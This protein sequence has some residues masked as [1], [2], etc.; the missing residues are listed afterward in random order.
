MQSSWPVEGRTCSKDQFILNSVLIEEMTISMGKSMEGNKMSK[1]AILHLSDLHFRNSENYKPEQIQ[2][3]INAIRNTVVDA[4]YLLLIVSGDLVHDG[5]DIQYADFDR[6]LADLKNSI[7]KTYKNI[8]KV[9]FVCVPGNHDVD[10]TGGVYSKAELVDIAENNSFDEKIFEE[11]ARGESYFTFARRNNVIKDE[12][13]IIESVN[14]SFDN[15][16][17]KINL[18]NTAPFSARQSDDQGFHFIPTSLIDNMKTSEEDDYIFTVMHHPYYWF[19]WHCKHKLINSLLSSTDI[20]FLGHDHFQES[21]SI[22]QDGLST[23]VQAA[24][25]LSNLGNW[26]SSE[27]YV[28]LLDL[29]TREYSQVLCHWDEKSKIYQTD[30]NTSYFLSKNRRN[31]IGLSV[32]C[33]FLEYSVIDKSFAFGKDIRSYYVF[34]YLE[35]ENNK[36]QTIPTGVNY[37]EQFED[38]LKSRRRVLLRGGKESGKS[39]ASVM[40]HLELYRHYS[41]VLLNSDDFNKNNI[42]PNNPKSTRIDTIIENAIKREY[43]CLDKT[44]EQYF[45][46]PSEKKAIII[47]DFDYIDAKVQEALI[48]YILPRYDIVLLTCQDSII[49]DIHERARMDQLLD[50]FSEFSIWSFTGKKRSE[51]IER[52]AAV[53]D[54]KG[55]VIKQSV[56]IVNGL[57]NNMKL[58][59][60]WDPSFIIQLTL[61]VCENNG[62]PTKAEG[63]L[64]SDVVQSTITNMITPALK[65]CKFGIKSNY[66]HAILE[67]IAY[68]AHAKEEYPITY[69]TIEESINEYN[70]HHKY[71]CPIA[72]FIETIVRANIIRCVGSGYEFTRNSFYAFFVAKEMKRK[73]IDDDDYSIF[74]RT[75]ETAY[76][77]IN[78]YIILFFTYIMDSRK[79]AGQILDYAGYYTDSWEE[80]SISNPKQEYFRVLDIPKIEISGNEE[81]ERE[82]KQREEERINNRQMELL[83]IDPYKNIEDEEDASVG[84]SISL[85]IVVSQMLPNLS[86]L[87]Y[88]DGI[89]KAVELIYRMPLRIF[90]YWANAIDTEKIDVIRDILRINTLEYREGLSSSK[91][92]SDEEALQYLR[93]QSFA[94]L[95]EL[96]NQSMVNASRDTTYEYIDGFSGLQDCSDITYEIERLLSFEKRKNTQKCIEGF[97]S[98]LKKCKPGMQTV[99][100]QQV[101]KHFIVFSP[102][103]DNR[104]RQ[105]LY[106]SISEGTLPEKL[107]RIERKRHDTRT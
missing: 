99:L 69:E 1:L 19:G 35:E 53:S 80:F 65:K 89:D 21:H 81:E 44:V 17:V 94:L 59:Y 22:S 7:E 38:V 68:N 13:S 62:L 9:E 29:E 25:K 54:K 85:M 58:L 18:I 86:H 56:V 83:W 73:C 15:H 87:L 34:P 97:E 6:F 24:G 5:K 45:Q 31:E 14:Y 27:F 12:R 101:I 67:L 71:N 105:R 23:I 61:Y 52:V 76:K 43:D 4:N 70:A 104:G 46:L 84:R 96:I 39:I 91:E 79:F 48:S 16:I 75:I 8:L 66:A 37:I 93:K 30:R 49:Y 107:L 36:G 78:A 32:S 33:D 95:L 47:D 50:G 3:I 63:D 74:K 72:E 64:F 11:L 90:N 57:L 28:S 51:L 102:N 26:H 77:S 42:N 106:S 40:I 82:W 98:V 2:N 55:E 103:I 20:V 60:R 10:Q 100:V 41:C 92:M 88:E